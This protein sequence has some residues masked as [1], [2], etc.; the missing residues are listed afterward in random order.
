[1][2]AIKNSLV[3]LPFTGYPLAFRPCKTY[4]HIKVHPNSPRQPEHKAG[5]AF[6]NAILE[7]RF[8]EIYPVSVWKQPEVL[9]H[10]QFLN[11]ID[12]IIYG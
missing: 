8:W 1:M 9:S 10:P 3:G 7:S 11:S 2:S 4:P 12:T 5:Y 6:S